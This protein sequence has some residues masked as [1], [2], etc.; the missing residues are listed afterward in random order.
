MEGNTGVDSGF[1]DYGGVY[2]CVKPDLVHP[3]S[4][5]SHGEVGEY[6]AV[7]INR[8]SDELPP[9][10]GDDLLFPRVKQ[11]RKRDTA[12]GRNTAQLASCFDER[13]T[14]S[15][16]TRLYGC[17]GASR[18]AADDKNVSGFIY[19]FDK[20][21]LLS[22]SGVMCRS[23]GVCLIRFLYF[24]TPLLPFPSYIENRIVVNYA[25]I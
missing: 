14:N 12:S 21:L 17:D 23:S 18:S 13:R 15:S 3:V 7:K 20:A 5:R 1:L 11:S 24:A 6:P 19:F 25:T 4:L 2:R 10:S 8:P 16:A 9:D 22:R